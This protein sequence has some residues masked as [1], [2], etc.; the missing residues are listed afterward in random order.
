[1]RSALEMRFINCRVNS[2]ADLGL[3]F[4]ITFGITYV[5][6]VAGHRSFGITYISG[7]GGHR[8]RTCRR[9]ERTRNRCWD[10]LMMLSCNGVLRC[11]LSERLW[12]GFI[13]CIFLNDFLLFFYFYLYSCFYFFFFYFYFCFYFFL[14]F[15]FSLFY[16]CFF[17]IFLL[18]F[19]YFIFSIFV[20][21]FCVL[22]VFSSF[23]SVVCNV[24]EGHVISPNRV[25]ALLSDHTRLNPRP[26]MSPC[27]PHTS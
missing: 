16:F 9:E 10:Q 8:V 1:M 15:F 24:K 22:F 14:F 23:L 17:L 20:F 5:S 26:R 7:I 25:S 18:F 3:L 11:V 13:R 4:E 27:R 2:L 19:S 21:V 6:G 12:C